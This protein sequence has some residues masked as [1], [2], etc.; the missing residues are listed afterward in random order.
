[1]EPGVKTGEVMQWEQFYPLWATEVG[2]IIPEA[3]A[4]LWKDFVESASSDDIL[5]A[6]I[7]EIGEEYIAGKKRDGYYPSPILEQLRRA[8]SQRR[9]ANAAAAKGGGCDFC[10]HVGYVSVIDSGNVKSDDFPPDPTVVRGSVCS[11]PCPCCRAAEYES[12]ALRTRVEQRCRPN[13][14]ADELRPPCPTKAR[15]DGKNLI[16]E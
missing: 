2:S 16:W 8:Y 4:P 13:S 10:E 7:R 1:M 5:R 12:R 11:V 9:A 3:A 6:A 15:W 14:R